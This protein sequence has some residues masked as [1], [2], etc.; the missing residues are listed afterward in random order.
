MVCWVIMWAWLFS[1]VGVG[2]FLVV[3]GEKSFRSL[4]GVSAATQKRMDRI[5]AGKKKGK[6]GEKDNSNEDEKG[7]SEESS[8]SVFSSEQSVVEV[9]PQRKGEEMD[10]N[11]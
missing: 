11:D 4:I 8:D 3:T 5:F 2:I 9:R 7:S 6:K 10:I 1:R